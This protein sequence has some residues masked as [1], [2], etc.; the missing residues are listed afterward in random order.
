MFK[1]LTILLVMILC[2]L[3]G[4]TDAT[5]TIKT[6]YK[7]PTGTGINKN[8]TRKPA[9]DTSHFSDTWAIVI[10]TLATIMC[11]GLVLVLEA[12]CGDSFHEDEDKIEITD[13]LLA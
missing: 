1:K 5:V 4:S 13:S 3:S 11:C 9:D 6:N 2:F 10:I 8:P 7:A 12:K